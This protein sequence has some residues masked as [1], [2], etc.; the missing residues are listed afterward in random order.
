MGP[1]RP[2]G[3]HH[4]D[5]PARGR[6]PVLRSQ[7]E[8]CPR[9]RRLSTRRSVHRR[10]SGIGLHLIEEIGVTLE[11]VG[12]E[13]TP[14]RDER[15]DTSESPEPSRLPFH[16]HYATAPPSCSA[17]RRRLPERGVPAAWGFRHLMS[18]PLACG[19]RVSF[20]AGRPVNRHPARSP[21]LTKYKCPIAQKLSVSQGVSES[22]ILASDHILA[23][24][25]L[26]PYHGPANVPPSLER[27]PDDA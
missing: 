4:V 15:T 17:F 24:R 14:S 1:P 6:G 10:H 7:P 13:I 20:P 25:R 21:Y 23:R 5:L 16:P 9:T 2:T 26:V 18:P 3:L 27:D 8:P 11:P 12:G 19:Q 22:L